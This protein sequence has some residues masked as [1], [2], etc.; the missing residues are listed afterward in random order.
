MDFA[1][2]F[3]AHLFAVKQ[4]QESLRLKKLYKNEMAEH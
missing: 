3:Q 2:N 1:I 4:N